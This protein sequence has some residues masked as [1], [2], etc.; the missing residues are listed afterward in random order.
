MTM[1]MPVAPMP[2]ATSAPEPHQHHRHHQQH[3]HGRFASM[4]LPL[5]RAAH[6][7]RKTGVAVLP[8]A[9]ARMGWAEAEELLRG[10]TSVFVGKGTQMGVLGARRLGMLLTQEVAKGVRKVLVA[11]CPRVG[12]KGVFA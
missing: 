7:A 12:D 4:R 3:L 5:L 8:D 9:G 6:R 11:D 10:A 2:T 1:M